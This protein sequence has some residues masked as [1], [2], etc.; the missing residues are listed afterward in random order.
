ME[1][2]NKSVCEECGHK[3]EEICNTCP[4][5]CRGIYEIKG[6]NEITTHDLTAIDDIEEHK[7][8]NR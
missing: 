6:E 5:L 7:Q 8:R 4:D 1:T 3:N 2:K